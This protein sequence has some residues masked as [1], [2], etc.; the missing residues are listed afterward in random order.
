MQRFQ[1]LRYLQAW[2]VPPGA[3]KT[4]GG[5]RISLSKNTLVSL[6]KLQDVISSCHSS[7]MS[8]QQRGHLQ[9]ADGVQRVHCVLCCQTLLLPKPWSKA[10]SAGTGA[11]AGDMCQVEGH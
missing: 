11:G 5:P 3:N 9:A 4:P 7:F 10:L 2:T 8:A 1:N 6:G